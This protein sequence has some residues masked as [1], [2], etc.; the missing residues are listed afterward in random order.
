M[1]ESGCDLFTT[2]AGATDRRLA[3]AQIALSKVP[4]E[5]LPGLLTSRP[6]SALSCQAQA[7]GSS[8]QG[9]SCFIL[10]SSYKDSG[11]VEQ[12]SESSRLEAKQRTTRTFSLLWPPGKSRCTHSSPEPR[13]FLPLRSPGWLQVTP[14]D[15]YIFGGCGFKGL[16]QAFHSPL[17]HLSVSFLFVLC[18]MEVGSSPLASK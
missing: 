3:S 17:L 13:G 18:Y 2:T 5:F 10:L 7:S 4:L 12:S 1:P 15:L 14:W 8:P 6:V 16:S 11:L 9:L